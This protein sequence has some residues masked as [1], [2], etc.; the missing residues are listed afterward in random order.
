MFHHVLVSSVKPL[1]IYCFSECYVRVCAE[2]IHLSKNNDERRRPS[3]SIK[4]KEMRQ[5]TV[6]G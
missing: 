3:S 6:V 4:T 5:S 1:R 2:S